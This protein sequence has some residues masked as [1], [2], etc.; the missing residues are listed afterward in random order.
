MIL[1]YYIFQGN[2]VDHFSVWLFNYGSQCTLAQYWSRALTHLHFSNSP[3][4]VPGNEDYGA[5]ASWLLFSSLGLF[6]RA[7]SADFMVGS[8]RVKEASLQLEHL[9]GDTSTLEI[10]TENNSAENVYVSSLLVNGEEYH[11]AIIDRSVL[12]NPK[13]CNLKFVMSSVPESSLC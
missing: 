1:L 7:G 6:P 10:I 5:M 4:G 13:G 12:M 8:P 2:E 11:S 9:N 3:H